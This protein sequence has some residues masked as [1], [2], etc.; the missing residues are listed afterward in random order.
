MTQINLYGTIQGGKLI[1]ANRDS[2]DKWVKTL[3]EG[4]NLVIKFNVSKSYK[5]NRQLRLIYA[6][7]RDLSKRLG[8]S[9]EEVKTL[10]KM[11]QGLCACSKINGEDVHFCKSIADMDKREISTFITD[12][13][14]W[15]IINLDHKLLT[16]EDLQFL[17][18]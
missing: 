18:S 12:I 1:L 2:L 15:S 13:N 17:K 3:L 16:Y 14:E 8:Y 11:Y 9:V 7:L 10:M 4:E 5:S 6:M